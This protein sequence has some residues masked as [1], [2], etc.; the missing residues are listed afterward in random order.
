MIELS[1][2][3]FPVLLGALFM[4]IASSIIHMGPFWHRS[5]FPPLP[6]ED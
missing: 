6:D 4:F 5:D 3:W 2:L 1:A